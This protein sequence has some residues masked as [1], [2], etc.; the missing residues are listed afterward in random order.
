MVLILNDD[1]RI[2]LCVLVGHVPR[3]G[4]GGGAAADPQAGPL[5]QGIQSETAMLAQDQTG[6]VLDRPRRPCAGNGSG[7]LETGARR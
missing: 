1:E 2:A 3:R 5:A 6:V 4:G 7:I